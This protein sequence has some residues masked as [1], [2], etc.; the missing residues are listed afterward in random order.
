MLE[1]RRAG[2][3]DLD[4]VFALRHEVF[5]AEQG[6]P[7]ELERDELDPACEHVVA[8]DGDRVVGTGRLLPSTGGV[9]VVGRI[10]VAR[11]RR[12]SGV[13]SAVL[14]ALEALAAARG[15]AVVE[16]HAQ[17]HAQSFY[18]HRGYVAEGDV[19]DDA[20]LPH[21]TMRKAL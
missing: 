19:Y 2:R 5:V 18:E 15:D 7:V 10:A 8:R 12:T 9:G 21:V 1:V 14:L 4:E 6:V 13:G 20:G 16:L 3:I 17:T 11:E